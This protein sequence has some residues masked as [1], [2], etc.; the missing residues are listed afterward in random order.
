MEDE[1]NPFNIMDSS[2]VNLSFGGCDAHICWQLCSRR[3]GRCESDSGLMI[4]NISI[5][6]DSDC[7]GFPV[8]D[9]E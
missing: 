3:N 1:D 5:I 9:F 7:Y 8:H 6:C 4:G 2:N